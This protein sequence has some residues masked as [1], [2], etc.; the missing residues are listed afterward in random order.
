MEW[1]QSFPVGSG[2]LQLHMRANDL[3][4][5]NTVP[6][7]LN[8]RFGNHG[9]HDPDKSSLREPWEEDVFLD[10]ANEL[11]AQCSLESELF[12]DPLEESL[13]AGAGSELESRQT[14]GVSLS[15]KNLLGS[16]LPL[17]WLSPNTNQLLF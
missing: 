8:Y 12:E 4:N 5:V 6:Y 16:R 2:T 9:T 10:S 13:D 11:S 17:V 15:T 14:S 1:A 3:H 7:F